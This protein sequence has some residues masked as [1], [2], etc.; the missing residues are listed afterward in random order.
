VLKGLVV[1][2]VAAPSPP[3]WDALLPPEVRRLP[4]ELARIDA[5]LDDERF[6][7]PWRALF[8]RPTGLGAGGSQGHVPFEQQVQATT[9]RSYLGRQGLE[10]SGAVHRGLS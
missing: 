5:Y 8:A 10:A 3:A 9:H 4:D 2:R 7:T 1:L 6:I